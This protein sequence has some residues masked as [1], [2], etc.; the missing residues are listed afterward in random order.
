MSVPGKLAGCVIHSRSEQPLLVCLFQHCHCDGQGRA[1][2]AGFR[3]RI[4]MP[5]AVAWTPRE[6]AC[7]AP[8]NK[9][10]VCCSPHIGFGSREEQAAS[11]SPPARVGLGARSALGFIQCPVSRAQHCSARKQEATGTLGRC[12]RVSAWRGLN[13]LIHLTG[14]EPVLPSKVDAEPNAKDTR[15]AKLHGWEQV[16]GSVLYRCSFSGVDV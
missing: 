13:L 3:Q 10:T 15:K 5:R 16:W 2:R 12:V 6:Q 7:G 9:R 11:A 1:G 14:K 4:Q 8:C